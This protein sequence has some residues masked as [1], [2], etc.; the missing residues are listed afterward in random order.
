MTN[1]SASRK[2]GIRNLTQ[3]VLQSK[4]IEKEFRDHLVKHRFTNE[5]RNIQKFLRGTITFEIILAVFYDAQ[6]GLTWTTYKTIP[7]Y[8]REIKT[9]VHTK[10]CT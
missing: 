7:I 4:N 2:G 8:P 6:C 9:Y 5:Q 10:M 3:Y 1:S